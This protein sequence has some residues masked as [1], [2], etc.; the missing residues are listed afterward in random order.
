MSKFT[1]GPWKLCEV[2]DKCKHLCPATQDNMSLLT[3][4]LEYRD[5]DKPTYFGAV[6]NP[7]DARL[8]AAAPD[9]YEACKEF[10]RKCDCGETRSTRS[11]AQMKAALAKADEVPDGR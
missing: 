10:V 2:G 3:V 4:A 5:D 11:Y 7:A 6:Y 1:P 9:M 8:I